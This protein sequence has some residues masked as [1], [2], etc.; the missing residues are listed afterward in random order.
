M[1]PN[2]RADS[3]AS[4]QRV[5]QKHVTLPKRCI[6]RRLLY[7]QECLAPPQGIFQ[8]KETHLTNC[9][10]IKIYVIIDVFQFGWE[11]Y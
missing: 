3:V 10:I 5:I 8:I 7:H 2:S 1:V 6:Y 11:S 4:I 9:K